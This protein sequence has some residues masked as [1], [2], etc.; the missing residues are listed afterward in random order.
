M[1]VDKCTP[2][3]THHHNQ[4]IAQFYYLLSQSNLFPFN[5]N[6]SP[7]PTS[8]PCSN[9]MATPRMSYKWN[10][11]VYSLWF[12]L[13][14]SSKMHFN[15]SVLLHE[16]VLHSFYCWAVFHCMCT[17][18]YLGLLQWKDIWLFPGLVIQNKALIDMCLLAFV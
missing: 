2:A 16:S 4:G 8:V 15:L 17:T 13:F 9:G 12:W 10:P 3:W 14:P 11:T 5:V 1:S 18:F 6:H 7:L